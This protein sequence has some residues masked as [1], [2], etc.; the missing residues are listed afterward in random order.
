ML[1]I[2]QVW[3]TVRVL[4]SSTFKD[5]HAERGG[6]DGTNFAVLHDWCRKADIAGGHENNILS[7]L[8]PKSA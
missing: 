7:I 5:M 8:C 3:R 4:I 1:L 6:Y 2:K